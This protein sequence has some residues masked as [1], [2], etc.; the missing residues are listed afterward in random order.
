MTAAA[1]SRIERT[2][3][4]GFNLSIAGL[5]RRSMNSHSLRSPYKSVKF[6]ERTEHTHTHACTHARTWML[7]LPFPLSFSLIADLSHL[8]HE[9]L[10]CI[11]EYQDSFTLFNFN[12]ICRHYKS[13]REIKSLCENMCED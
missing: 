5:I 13:Q 8:H 10:L 12:N 9:K 7:S 2:I 4:L 6:V 1:W 3:S 11:R